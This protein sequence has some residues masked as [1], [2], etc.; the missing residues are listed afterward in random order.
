MYYDS[1][2]KVQ[3]GFGSPSNCGILELWLN[4]TKVSYVKAFD[5]SLMPFEQNIG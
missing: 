4:L 1:F 2:V 3:P 5:I